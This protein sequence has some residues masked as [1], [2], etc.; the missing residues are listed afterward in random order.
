MAVVAI[1]DDV[2][3]NEVLSISDKV[4]SDWEIIRTTC[5]LVQA[6]DP[7]FWVNLASEYKVALI[8]FSRP[9]FLC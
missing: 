6:R 7:V 2:L 4:Y 9:I 5:N 3:D 8:N 1:G